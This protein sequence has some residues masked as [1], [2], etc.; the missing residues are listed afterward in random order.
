MPPDGRARARRHGSRS[1]L[2]GPVL[3]RSAGPAGTR[4]HAQGWPDPR[5]E[6]IAVILR[7]VLT[8]PRWTFEGTVAAITSD[9]LKRLVLEAGLEIYRASSEEI[10]IAERVRMHLMDSGVLL[11]LTDEP[12]LWLTI[13]AQRSD[14]PNSSTDELSKIIRN[15]VGQTV[16]DLGFHEAQAVEREITNP[17]DDGHVLDVWYELTFA[18]R[19]QSPDTLVADLKSALSVSKCVSP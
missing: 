19:I 14:F 12:E 10:R 18:K 3:R 7:G 5:N 15:A 1:W 11:R 13:R 16:T 4:K 9:E 8:C 2:P 17:V 6:L